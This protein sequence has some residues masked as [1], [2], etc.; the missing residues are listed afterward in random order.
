MFWSWLEGSVGND[1][2]NRPEDIRRLAVALQ[3]KGHLPPD[4]DHAHGYLTRPL[5]DAVKSYQSDNS[6]QRDGIVKADG[7]TAGSLFGFPPGG[8]DDK[9]DGQQPPSNRLFRIDAPVGDGLE[10]RPEDVVRVKAGL[11]VTGDLNEEAASGPPELLDSGTIEGLKRFQ[12]RNSLRADGWLVPGRETAEKLDDEIRARIEP[13]NLKQ[14]LREYGRLGGRRHRKFVERFFSD[15]YYWALRNWEDY[16]SKTRTLPN[17]FLPPWPTDPLPKRPPPRAV[18]PAAKGTD[19]RGEEP[20]RPTAP[21]FPAKQPVTSEARKGR[22]PPPPI[23]DFSAPPE[24]GEPPKTPKKE[25]FPAHEAKKGDV[26]LELPE[27]DN[28]LRR[29]LIVENR[30]NAETEAY[31]DRIK[32]LVLAAAKEVKGCTVKHGGGAFNERDGTRQKQSYIKNPD[33]ERKRIKGTKGASFPDLTFE[34]D[35]H[36]L[37]FKLFINSYDAYANLDPDEREAVQLEKL[38]YN[39]GDR[40]LVQGVPKERRG[41]KL[42]DTAFQGRIE[43]VLKTVERGARDPSIRDRPVD[44]RIL[45]NFKV[46]RRAK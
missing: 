7:E 27:P 42:N 3:T 17:G 11:L 5:V 26:V 43:R 28:D 12:E 33:R 14:L 34:V 23:K 13:A 37:K 25:Q 38:R 16:L 36:G 18:P 40:A 32:K 8:G 30:G 41:W 1:Q 19:R 39:Y 6:L 46:M 4:D 10:S 35:C 24:P 31:D 21:G 44:Q 2:Q 22:P 15:G 45:R 29:P 9:P 20:A